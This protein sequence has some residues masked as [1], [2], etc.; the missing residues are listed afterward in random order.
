[1]VQY[2]FSGCYCPSEDV[3][4]K[5]EYRCRNTS[6]Q[7]D[8]AFVSLSEVTTIHYLSKENNEIHPHKFEKHFQGTD[9]SYEIERSEF[10]IG[11]LLGKGNF[12]IVYKGEL[13]EPGGYGK[14]KEIAIKIPNTSIN[15]SL[16]ISQQETY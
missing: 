8:E 9:K 2:H 14:K 1:M 3:E 4:T 7:S 15:H 16:E 10:T 5:A 6:N 11:E 12:G 13:H